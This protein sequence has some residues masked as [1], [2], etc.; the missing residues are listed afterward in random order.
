[1]RPQAR[2][3]KFRELNTPALETKNYK[4]IL[5]LQDG[6]TTTQTVPVTGRTALMTIMKLY[7]P[8]LLSSN[9]HA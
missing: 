8:P 7:H 4:S 9:F 5:A 3:E 6:H 1:M 2:L